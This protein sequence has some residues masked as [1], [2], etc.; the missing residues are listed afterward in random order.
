MRLRFT[1]RAA[2]D[3]REIADYIKAGNPQAAKR[4]RAAI[5]RSLQVLV[6]FPRVGR[7]QS[8]K[9]VRKLIAR[10]YPYITYYLIDGAA[11][12]IAILTV[13]HPSRER[14]YSDT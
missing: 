5:I 8:K 4:T 10:R 13:Q 3:L 9:E 6:L 12:E 1:R 11:E 2:S 14:P 7:Q